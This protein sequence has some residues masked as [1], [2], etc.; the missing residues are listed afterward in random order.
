MIYNSHVTFLVCDECASVI[1]MNERG[2][3]ANKKTRHGF[4]WCTVLE[5][6][7]ETGH[8]QELVLF[9][10]MSC[11]AAAANACKIK[12]FPRALSHRRCAIYIN[13]YALHMHMQFVRHKHTHVTGRPVSSLRC[14]TCFCRWLLLLLM[15]FLSQMPNSYFRIS[16]III[17]LAE[18][19]E[20][21]A[22]A[23]M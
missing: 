22:A 15:L 18:A 4:L 16:I 11:V 7:A 12:P 10:R 13:I 14:A 21:A 23:A 1:L 3:I 6:C 2:R 20:A 19:T 9:A 8:H 17:S 5:N